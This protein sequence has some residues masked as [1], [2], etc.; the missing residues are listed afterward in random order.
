MKTVRCPSSVCS[1]R[2]PQQQTRCCRLLLSAREL[3]ISIDCCSSGVRRA[4]ASSVTLSAY[5]GS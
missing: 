3:E 1:N 2:D 5:V 4:N